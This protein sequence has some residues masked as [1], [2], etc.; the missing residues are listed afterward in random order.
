[1]ANVDEDTLSHFARPEVVKDSKNFTTRYFDIVKLKASGRANLVPG[2]KQRRVQSLIVASRRWW[3]PFPSGEG[4]PSPGG[5]RPREWGGRR[6]V[7][8]S[9]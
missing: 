9:G 1:L 5:A 8:R 3:G 2:C 7:Q 6:V 4:S